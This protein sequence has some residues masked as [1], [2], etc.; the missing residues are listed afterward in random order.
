M[1]TDDAATIMRM[2]IVSDGVY[3][4]LVKQFE[5][6]VRNVYTGRKDG[7][8]RRIKRL[9]DGS[10]VGADDG[11]RIVT[12]A[13]I[14]STQPVPM[15]RAFQKEQ[16]LLAS[17]AQWAWHRWIYGNR[18]EKVGGKNAGV[19]HGGVKRVVIGKV[20]RHAGSG[21]EQSL[22][23]GRDID[24]APKLGCAACGDASARLSCGRCKS[25]RYCNAACQRLH[26]LSH[27]VICGL[28][29]AGLPI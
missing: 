11:S 17:D 10:F 8:N 12:R 29:N 4:S 6:G 19:V 2:V 5:A 15:N 23:F 14:G 28:G 13:M 20:F 18:D 26:W 27:K 9:A 21:K 25:V 22:L 1:A 24:R 3:A 7:S 16:A